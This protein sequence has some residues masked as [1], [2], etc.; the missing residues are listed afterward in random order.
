MSTYQTEFSLT[1][2]VIANATRLKLLWEIFQGE[3]LSVQNLAIQTG[4]SEQNAS[5]QLRTLAAKELIYPCREKREVFYKPAKPSTE[6][7]RVLLP[8]LIKC[9]AQNLSF[10]TIIHQAT[11]F[12]HERRIQI[13]R[14]LAVSDECFDSLLKKTGMTIPAQNRHLR[15]LLQRNIIRNKNMTY[16]LCEPSSKLSQCLLGLATKAG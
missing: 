9:H 4:T 5:N 10:Q 6:L 8:V 2:R 7:A 12:T 1:C 14:C 16:Q 3:K 15:K 13:V 11:A